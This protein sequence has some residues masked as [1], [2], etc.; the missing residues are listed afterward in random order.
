MKRKDALISALAMVSLAVFFLVFGTQVTSASREI[1]VDPGSGNDQQEGT[2]RHPIK[3]L[4]R[5]LE[6]VEPGETIKLAS[7]IYQEAVE[8]ARAGRAD[9]HIT[10]EPLPGAAPII[11]GQDFKRN[12]PRIV[13]SFYTLRG[14]EIRNTKEGLRI[15]GAEGVTIEQLHLHHIGNECLRL[16]FQAQ[17]NTIRKNRV[18]DCGV[19]GNGEGI[20]VGTAP[21]QR[22]KNQGN[23]DA[24]TGNTL[25]ENEIWNVEEAI[26]I[27]EDASG[28]IVSANTVSTCTDEESGC[29]NTRGDRNTFTGNVSSGSRGAG[30][31]FGGDVATSPSGKLVHYGMNNTLRRNVAKDNGHAGY[32]FMHGPQD[33]DCSNTGSGNQEGLFF[34]GD[35]V[36]HFPTCQPPPPPPATTNSPTPAAPKPSDTTPQPPPEETTNTVAAAAPEAPAPEETS[37]PAAEPQQQPQETEPRG[38]PG[39]ILLLLVGAIAAIAAGVTIIQR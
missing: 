27:K 11:D 29:I 2:Q 7:G 28:T 35:K 5:A 6:L 33:V 13:H 18:H 39:R 16:R 8:T 37:P 12:A 23:P 19:K 38:L 25:A 31:R 34:F 1:V 10:I 20:Y 30:F 3:T 9:A 24:S 17:K 15:E 4:K 21:E 36:M 22:E 32:K 14:L 26:D